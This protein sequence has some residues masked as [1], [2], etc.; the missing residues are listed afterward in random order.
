MS[1]LEHLGSGNTF[2]NLWRKN[3]SIWCCSAERGEHKK[4]E[5]SKKLRECD[6]LFNSYVL[7][8][9]LSW[10]PEWA[11]ARRIVHLNTE[12]EW[13]DILSRTGEMKKDGILRNTYAIYGLP[14]PRRWQNFLDN[15]NENIDW[16][17]L[18]HL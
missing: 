17:A 2:C 8:H 12:T 6:Q 18:G 15:V 14:R 11:A 3:L 9:V 16:P 7:T 1:I 5:E 10:K 4:F 13:S